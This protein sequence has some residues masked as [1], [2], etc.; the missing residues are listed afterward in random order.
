MSGEEK[1]MKLALEGHNLLIVGTAGSGKTYLV[2]KL[3]ESLIKL[4]KHVQITCST[5]IAC[6][7]YLKATTVHKFCGLADGRNNTKDIPEIVKSHSA[8]LN[9]IEQCDVLFIDECS[10]ISE[11]TLAQIEKACSVKDNNKYF[12]GMQVILVGD[13]YQLPPVPNKHMKDMGNYLFRSNI[14]INCFP[15]TVYLKENF[16]TKEHMLIN[17]IHEV[18]IGHPSQSTMQ[19]IKS[20]PLPNSETLSLKLFATNDLVTDYNRKCLLEM[21]GDICQYTEKDKGS[22]TPL[23]ACQAERHIWLKVGVPVV[24]I[25]NLTDVLVNGL[26][27]TITALAKEGPTVTFPSINITTRISIVNFAGK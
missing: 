6:S 22:S 10:M 13:F 20:L 25:R 26:Q 12:G 16:R 27:G 1:A 8:L 15:H 21:I 18:N 24:L 4:G 2:N 19:Y 9:Q 17:A 23:K 11:Q 5:G 3:A 14:F 7:N